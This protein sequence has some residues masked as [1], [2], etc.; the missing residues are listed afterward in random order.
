MTSEMYRLQKWIRESDNIVFISGSAFSEAAGFPDYRRMEEGFLEKYRYPTD[1][2][3]NMT[4]MKQYP[5][6]F[7][8]WYRERVLAPLLEAKPAAAHEFFAQLEEC[9]KLKGIVT[10]NIDGLHQEA[11][12]R[13]VMETHGSVMRSWCDKC[14]KFLDF[15]FIA[16]SPTPVPYCNVDMCGAVVQPA[17]VL[18]EEPYDLELISQAMALIK[19]A[20]TL[21][22]DGSSIKEF[23]V[24]NLLRC[25]E[26]H[27]LI[28]LNTPPMIFD[29][30]AGL[31]VRGDYNDIFSQITLSD[32]E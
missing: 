1:K 5:F 31:T 30:R 17:I 8:K 24:P 7:F 6:I 19:A 27:K 32:A 9:G 11:G 13:N 21:I 10:V 23:P 29:S 14:E 20:D 3:L 28:M 26:G 16:D 2:M 18:D 12:N 15:F 4:F 25:Y 22:V